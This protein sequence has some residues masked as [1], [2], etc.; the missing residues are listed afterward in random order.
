MEARGQLCEDP[1]IA[2]NPVSSSVIDL[3]EA[4]Y[5]LESS[6]ADWLTRLV[7]VGAPVFDHGLGFSMGEFLLVRRDGGAEIT[8]GELRMRSLPD[9]YAARAAASVEVSTPEFLAA[10]NSHGL[11][12]TLSDAAKDYPDDAARALRAIGYS[13]MLGILAIDP[14]GVGMNIVVPLP[15]TTRLSSRARE[16]WQMVGAHVAAAF[17]LRQ[18]LHEHDEEPN[19]APTDLPGDAE[20]VF[21]AGGLRIVEAVGPAQ[22]ANAIDSLRQ[23]ARDVDRSRGWLR[24]DN[25]EEALETWKALVSGRWSMVDWFDTDGRRFVLALPNPPELS[26]PRG[27]TE[28]EA[29][30]VNFVVLGQSSKLIAYRV[31]LSPARVSG[32]LKS[33]MRKLDVTSAAQLVEKL[34][35]MTP[36]QSTGDNESPG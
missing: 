35:P 27:L 21:D 11:A 20:A 3:V 28:Q 24:R 22:D 36:P 19:L 12:S 6:R 1:S 17:R 32:L 16:R 10:M 2:S 26:D 9:D 4:A 23:A 25:P 18:A 30:V 31:G 34:Q 7:E 14:S 29:Q 8:M 13:D 15:E 33:A 5:D